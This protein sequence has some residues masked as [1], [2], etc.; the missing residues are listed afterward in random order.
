MDSSSAILLF[1]AGMFELALACY[2]V[3][4]PESVEQ[5]LTRPGRAGADFFSMVCSQGLMVIY[6]ATGQGD[7]NAGGSPEKLGPGERD[8][9]SLYARGKG[10]FIV[11]DDKKA[12]QSCIKKKIPYVNALL[13]VRIFADS[14]RIRQESYSAAFEKLAQIGWYSPRIVSFARTCERERI[15]Y[16]FP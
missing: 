12:A 1:K 11:V 16:F 15:S 3:V 13:L 6:D 8:A 4:I 9:L 10:D 7:E 5:E 2:T 14:G